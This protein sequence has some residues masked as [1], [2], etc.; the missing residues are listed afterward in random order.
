[1]VE[2]WGQVYYSKDVTELVMPNMSLSGSI[3]H[4][5]GEFYQYY[6]ACLSHNNLSGEIPNYHRKF[7]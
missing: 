4:E 1:M 2:L 5:I 6:K 7:G 3:P